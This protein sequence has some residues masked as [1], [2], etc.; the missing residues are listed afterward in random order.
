VV[1]GIERRSA[2]IV[3]PRRWIPVSLM[4]GVV[5]VLSDARLEHDPEVARLMREAQS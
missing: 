4:R 2:R 3:Y 5:N 1:D